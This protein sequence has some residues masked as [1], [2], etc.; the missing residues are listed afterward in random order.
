MKKASYKLKN[1]L[2]L[3]ILGKREIIF[4]SEVSNKK[5]RQP[6]YFSNIVFIT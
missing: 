3:K 1:T 4:L 6:K 5:Q 2:I